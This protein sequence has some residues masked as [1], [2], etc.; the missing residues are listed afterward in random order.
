MAKWRQRTANPLS[1]DIQDQFQLSPFAAKLFALRGKTTAEEIN[2]WLNAT[3]NDLADPSLMHDMDQAVARIEQ[4]IDH[5]EKITIY[6]DY[7]A[8]GMT[9]TAILMETLGILGADVH[10]FIPNRFRDGYGPNMACYQQLVANGTKLIITVDNGV[11]GAEEVAYAKKHGVDTIVTD[12]HTFQAVKP[13]CAA[14]LHCNYP[15]Q[16]YPFDDYCG[17]GVAYTLARALMQDPMP[18]LLDLALIGTIGDM[19]KVS[20]EGHIIVKQGLKRLNQTERL[21]LRALIKQAGLTPGQ[22]NETDVGFAIAPRLNA[23]GR[24]G[25]ARLAVEL[26]LTD[27]EEQA[28]DLAKQVEDLNNQRK[29]L[30]DQVYQSALQ[31]VQANNWGTKHTLTLYDPNWHEG[32]LGLVANKIC[33]ELGKP[34]V[35][36]TRG[37]SGEL[38]GSGRAL[39]GF[40]LFDALHPLKEKLLTHFGGHD[41]ACGLSLAPDNLADLRTAF[42]ASYH[43]PQVP[44]EDYDF[45]LDASQVNNATLADLAL[46]GPFGTDNPQPV[47]QL[48]WPQVTSSQLMGAGHDHLR[49]TCQGLQIIGFGYGYL[50]KLLPL[51]KHLYIH[52]ENNYWRGQNRVQAQICGVEYG[53]PAAWQNRSIID[54]RFDNHQLDL[55]D[56]YLFF[57]E[58][59]IVKAESLW[60]L[61]PDKV[62]LVANYQ[63]SGERVSLVDA[64]HNR[65]ELDQALQQDYDLL[66]L[67]F[68][69]DNLPVKT[70]P[71]QA[72]FAQVW[73]YVVQHPG[74]KLSDYRQV[75]PYLGLSAESIFFILR[76]FFQLGLLDFTGKQVTAKTGQKVSSLTASSYYSATQSQLNFVTQLRTMP[77][78]QLMAYAK[79]WNY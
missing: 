46:V 65:D 6:G 21:G 71:Q 14:L 29:E 9:A 58:A 49:L 22:I 32:V 56:R 27:N 3:E 68:S 19:V 7:D 8:D 42:E 26:L 12:H 67:R 63:T 20:G 47:F 79:R 51:V 72:E 60:Q 41:Y 50:Q 38:K 24:L 36:L 45:Q 10:F 76:V 61:D 57:D 15:G 1:Q 18:E 74:L 70:L 40:N 13:D 23:V 39:A 55:A 75:G 69:L 28:A 37:K 4:A 77:T 73:H 35:L 30:T 62:D 48:Q 64:P 59:N 17:A 52:L 34:V 78:A 54:L 33:R 2:W 31:Q 16:A 5:G 44:T 43:R 11:T 25:D 53:V 66:Y